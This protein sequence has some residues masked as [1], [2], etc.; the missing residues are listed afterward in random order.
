MAAIGTLPVLFAT[1]IHASRPAAS[2]VGSGGLY[3]CTTHDLLYQTDGSSWTTWATLGSAIAD[4]LDLPTAETN[5]TLVLA[6]DGA[7][8]VEF[9]AETGGGGGGGSDPVTELFG[10]P[11]T[12]FEF[13]TS[14]LA[15][16]TALGS[17]DAENADTTVPDHYYVRK[18]GSGY[19]WVGRYLT[20]PSAPW[21]AISKFACLPINDYHSAGLFLGVASPGNMDVIGYGHGSNR[22]ITTQRVTPSAF[23]STITNGPQVSPEKV[24]V[25]IIVNSSS[26]V[27]YLWSL[28][29]YVWRTLTLAR[30]PS[31]TIG[32]VGIAIK[33]ESGTTDFTTTFDYLRIW[34]SAKTFPGGM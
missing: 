23:G 12:A 25:A 24:Y 6:P 27:D 16:L 17:P 18:S 5:D 11:D 10:T 2:D 21:T 14:S 32:T 3:S 7:G 22:M 20:P 31:I 1:G 29:G 13:S 9:R 26:D 19:A 15:G 8:G 33:C 30:N 4:I 34:N 28:D